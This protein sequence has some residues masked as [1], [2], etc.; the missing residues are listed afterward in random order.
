MLYSVSS[1]K[2]LGGFLITVAQYCN[3]KTVFLEN[4]FIWQM[5]NY[6][7][8]ITVFFWIFKNVGN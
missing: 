8:N 7:D 3:L 1:A 4:K 5:S 6:M 2:R